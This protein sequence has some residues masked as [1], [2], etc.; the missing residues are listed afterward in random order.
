LKIS[1]IAAFTE[2]GVIGKDGKIPWTLKEDLKHFRNKTEGSSIVMGRKTYESIGRPLP[3]RLN[4]VMTK[5][6]K[7]LEGVKEVSNR[8]EALEIASSYSNEVFI[9]GGEKIYEEFLPLATKMY[10][11]KIDIK[12]KGDAFFPK[13]NVN[14]WEELSRQDKEDLNQNI[15]YC[16]LEY[17]RK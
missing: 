6:P 8:K 4:I 5:N 3:N 15:K 9:I 11:T 1:L 14:D 7:M 2:E 16:F 12:T 17:K 13:W 10:L